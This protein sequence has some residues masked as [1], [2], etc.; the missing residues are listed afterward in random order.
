MIAELVRFRVVEAMA[1]VLALAALLLTLDLLHGCAPPVPVQTPA[2]YSAEL[3]ACT[4]KSATFAASV[5]CEN[6][7]RARYGRPPRKVEP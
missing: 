2:M 6:E 3:A 1:F 5:Q 7:V 4:E